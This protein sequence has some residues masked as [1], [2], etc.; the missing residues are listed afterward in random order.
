MECH[1]AK[2]KRKQM[3]LITLNERRY[4]RI[5]A[6]RSICIKCKNRQNQAILLR[7]VY[8]NDKTKKKSKEVIP[9]EVKR[10]FIWREEAEDFGQKGTHK[11]TSELLSC[12]T[13]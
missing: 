8:I 2:K 9:T 7:D 5:H 6:A 4:K 10:V 3:N 12:S 1:I 13:S 11:G